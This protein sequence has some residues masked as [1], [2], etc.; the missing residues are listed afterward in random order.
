M[1][2]MY[3]RK[4]IHNNSIELCFMLTYFQDFGHAERRNPRSSMAFSLNHW[5]IYQRLFIQCGTHC[6]KWKR[7]QRKTLAV[8][9]LAVFNLRLKKY[10]TKCRKSQSSLKL[11]WR[12]NDSDI[13][14]TPTDKI[15][16]IE[17]NVP[18]SHHHYQCTYKL[19]WHSK[20]TPITLCINKRSKPKQRTHPHEHASPSSFHM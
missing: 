3:V 12:Q 17:V 4:S 5:F 14:A 1:V 18:V 6:T 11:D 16:K 2:R 19:R 9:S 10:Q 15:P 7:N 13:R 20:Q 8:Y